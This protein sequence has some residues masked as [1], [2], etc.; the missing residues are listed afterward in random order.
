MPESRLIWF[1]ALRWGPNTVKE[2]KACPHGSNTWILAS[3]PSCP[4]P[5]EF[6]HPCPS[7]GAVHCAVVSKEMTA[8]S[9]MIS[10]GTRNDQ[11]RHTEWWPLHRSHR[12]AL[13]WMPAGASLIKR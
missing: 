2:W 11:S 6:T 3:E 10:L 7:Q 13:T 9:D 12:K 4:S 5:S 1:G 8:W